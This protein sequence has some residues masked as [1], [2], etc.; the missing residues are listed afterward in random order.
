MQELDEGYADSG[1]PVV[2]GVSRRTALK[3]GGLGLA[4]AVAAFLP[5]WAAAGVRKQ[6]VFRTCAGVKSTLCQQFP[7]K[8]GNDTN[9]TCISVYSH[10]TGT[11]GPGTFCAAGFAGE[12]NCSNTNSCAHSTCPQG[13]ICAEPKSTCC[14]LPVCVPLCGANQ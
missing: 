4:G 9:C 10:T 7:V 8:C 14:S 13:Y 3:V 6:K 12:F 5:G 2:G 11:G 1:E